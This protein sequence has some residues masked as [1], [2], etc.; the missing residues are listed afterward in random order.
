MEIKNLI[1]KKTHENQSTNSENQQY[2]NIKKIIML[3][4]E[5]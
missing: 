2:W 4:R 5:P 1:E 3:M